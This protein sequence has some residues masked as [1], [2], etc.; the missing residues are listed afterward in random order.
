MTESNF[1]NLFQKAICAGKNRK[2]RQAGEILEGLLFESIEQNGEDNFVMDLHPEI[3]IFL[4][5]AFHS[6]KDFNKAIQYFRLYLEKHSGDSSGWFFLARTL[7]SCHLYK[8]AFHSVRRSLALNSASPDS[9]SLLGAICLKIGKP[10]LARKAFLQGLELAP[11]NMKLHQGY[12]NTLFI[13]GVRQLKN[14]DF[15]NAVETFN[16]LINNNFDGVLPRLYLAHAYRGVGNYQQALIQYEQACC[17][18]PNDPHL[19]WYIVSILLESGKRTEA[20]RILQKF[21]L[22]EDFILG[23]EETLSQESIDSVII[24]KHLNDREYEK[25]VQAAGLALRKYGPHPVFHCLMG[26]ALY[27]KGAYETAMNHFNRA[28]ELDKN[29]VCAKYGIMMI[30]CKQK[31][32]NNLEK[33]LKR[34]RKIGCE[35]S[36]V[37]YYDC[38]CKVNKEHDPQKLLEHIQNFVRNYGADSNIMVALARLYF[39]VGLPDLALGW[40]EKV[41]T[42]NPDNE[43][44]YL[45]K[46]ASLELLDDVE[47]LVKTYGIY[48]EKWP[49]NNPIR[50]EFI[51]LL[52]KLEIWDKAADNTEYFVSQPGGKKF[53]RQMAFFRRKAKQYREAVIAYKTILRENPRDQIA[54]SNLIFCLDRMGKPKEGEVI[55][56]AAL[57]IMTPTADLLMIHALTLVHCGEIERALDVYRLATDK[58][59]DDYRTWENAGKVYEQQGIKEVAMQYYQAAEERK[60]KALQ[61][62]K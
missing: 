30:L 15:P 32:W 59:P 49:T 58:F 3:L 39:E 56:G 34:A 18:S 36:T 47:S 7:F 60:S 51:D 62:Q 31:K 35:E 9:Y 53:L 42:D 37:L 55:L 14:D 33:E 23:T 2:Y 4:G 57:K 44:A 24:K 52:I 26:E 40:Y 29:S 45:G 17:Y 11:Q 12:N 13:C 10:N 50:S 6:L 43:E 21:N 20:F 8:D 16:Y 22:P 25:A 1:Q 38:L 54:L 46:I 61:K 27:G 5:R 28:T 48:L 19:P 41:I